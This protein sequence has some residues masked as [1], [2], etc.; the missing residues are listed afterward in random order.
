MTET[1]G[2]FEKLYAASKM[3]LDEVNKPII[4]NK[5]KRKLHSAYDDADGKIGQAK[6]TIQK[7]REDFEKYDI[8]SVLEQQAII[9]KAQD[10]QADI[11]AEYLELFGKTMVIERD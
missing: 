6:M 9:R 3:V 11:K 1:Q 7:T 10:L 4:R 8:N 5:I 2:L